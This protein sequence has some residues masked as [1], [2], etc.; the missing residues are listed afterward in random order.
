VCEASANSLTPILLPFRVHGFEPY[1]RVLAGLDY[2]A[3]Q[4]GWIPR[5]NVAV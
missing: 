4:K 1:A 3:D 5:P 2:K